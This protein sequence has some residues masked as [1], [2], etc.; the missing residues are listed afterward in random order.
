MQI[1][2]RIDCKQQ[3]EP[4]PFTVEIDLDEIG[5]TVKPKQVEQRVQ[6]GQ[7]AWSRLTNCQAWTDWLLVAE[8]LDV[9]RTEAMQA[10]HTNKPEGRRY[11]EEYGDWLEANRFDC[12]NKTTRS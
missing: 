7:E 1:D 5:L 11:N 6:N 10:A 4:Q 2:N 9:G 12:V 8:A 3:D